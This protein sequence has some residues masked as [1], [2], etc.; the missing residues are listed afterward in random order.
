MKKFASLL[1]LAAFTASLTTGL[2]AAAQPS[3]QRPV[4][5]TAGAAGSPSA[6][7]PAAA[8]ARTTTTADYTEQSVGGD[9]VVKFAGD[10]LAGPAN[11]YYGPSIRPLP[12]VTRVG[13]I[14]PRVNFVSELLKS[15]ENL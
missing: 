1:S 6:G 11:P 13:L 7:P 14:R 10:E 4:A 12:G 15:V 5:G 2:D 8:P 3:S 9:Q